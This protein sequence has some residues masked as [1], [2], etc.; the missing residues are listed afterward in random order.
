MSFEV[1]QFSEILFTNT[2]WEW[3]LVLMIFHMYFKIIERDKK[4]STLL[5]RKQLFVLFQVLHQKFLVFEDVVTQKTSKCTS[6]R[7]PRECC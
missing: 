6:T 1:T 4:L 2:T 5:A 7:H 3:L